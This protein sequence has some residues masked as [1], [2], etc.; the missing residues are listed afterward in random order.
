MLSKMPASQRHFALT[1]TTLAILTLNSTPI[2]RAVTLNAM[3]IKERAEAI[4]NMTEQEK[5]DTANAS[6]SLRTI[7]NR[8]ARERRNAEGHQASR[9]DVENT[10]V[11]T[12]R[13]LTKKERKAKRKEDKRNVMVGE[14][15]KKA[16]R[17]A[18]ATKKFQKQNKLSNVQ[19]RQ[20]EKDRETQQATL[21]A[22]KVE[23]DIAEK[24]LDKVTIHLREINDGQALPLIQLNRFSLPCRTGI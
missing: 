6:A 23:K 14:E 20:K 2:E 4:E 16:D 8:L 22:T 18:L 11:S 13:N 3:S 1:L 15:K 5:V 19:I 21:V 17:K 24:E 10:C 7:Q 9:F 12:N